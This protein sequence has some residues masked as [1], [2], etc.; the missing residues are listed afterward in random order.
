MPPG[1]SLDWHLRRTAAL[2]SELE[3]LKVED[4][5]VENGDRPA[6]EVALEVLSVAGWI[7]VSDGHP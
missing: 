1:P 4:F 6:N 2:E 5:V 3:T 7:D